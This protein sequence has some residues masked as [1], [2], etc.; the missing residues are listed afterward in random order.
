MNEKIAFQT[1]H[2]TRVLLAKGSSVDA[3]LALRELCE[4]YYE[5]V[6]AFI[7][8]SIPYREKQN[9][10]A[11]EL[12]HEFFGKL[13]E[14]DRLRNLERDRGRFRSYLLGAVKNFLYDYR[15]K[16]N[17]EIRGGSF[18]QVT[19]DETLHDGTG[20]P[21]D[22]FFDRQWG[23]SLVGSVIRSL[24]EEAEQENRSEQFLTLKPFL[25]G[26]ANF[27]IADETENR[28]NDSVT[29]ESLNGTLRVALHRLRKKFR[30]K[31]RE[32][33]A[34]TLDDPREIEEEIR[35]LINSLLL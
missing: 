12:T 24:Q 7:E 16:Q 11:R 15:E 32:Q 21:G 9:E 14:G 2:W 28:P 25:I 29:G 6:R 26:G 34:S 3:K 27:E 19:L 23:L 22:A 5:P 1:T 10:L 20:F 4:R 35:Y 30:R 18:N 13:L 31:I 33:I 8:R 17:A